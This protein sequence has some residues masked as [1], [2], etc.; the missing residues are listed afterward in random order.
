[1]VFLIYKSFRPP[2]S[3]GGEV[4]A[5]SPRTRRFLFAKLFLLG[6][7][8]KRKSVVYLT[9]ICF[10]VLSDFLYFSRAALRRGGTRSSRFLL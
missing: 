2:F 8:F 3:K 10:R 6:Y 4:W 9:G 5:R 7:F 1:M